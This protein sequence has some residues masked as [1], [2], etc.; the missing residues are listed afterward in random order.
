[1]MSSPAGHAPRSAG[2]LVAV[3]AGFAAL[4]VLLWAV[5]MTVWQP[6]TEPVGPWSERLPEA[7]TYW[8]RDLRFLALMAVVSG[9]VLAGGGRR[10]WTLRAVLLGGGALAADVAVDRADPTGPGATV[11]LVVLGWLA[12]ALTAASAVRRDAAPGRDRAVLAGLSVVAAVLALVAVLTRAP[13]DREPELGPAALMTGLLLLALT[14]AAA[15]AAAPGRGRARTAVAVGVAVVGGVGLPLV[16]L[17]GPAD[18]LPPAA[19]LGAVLLVG[20]TVLTR[21]WSGGRPAWR[22]YALLVPVTLVVPLALLSGALLVSAV[23]G[24]GAPL[25]ALAGN[26]P[27]AG[28]DA[29]P[30]LAGLLAGLGTA[31]LHAG[32]T[33]RPA[34]P[35]RC[36]AG[37]TAST[38]GRTGRTGSPPTG[39]GR[40]R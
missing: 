28:S 34:A 29:L 8:A 24:L 17:V 20:V 31:L 5:G 30:S 12:V 36:V 35:P 27:I 10:P 18:R 14:V 15:L 7:H 40:R 22:R 38:A 39:S 23:L 21:P 3:G 19:V 6:L 37:T 13:T 16:R 26:S 1:M 32:V 33:R 4:A 9:L 11:S 25:T 2:R